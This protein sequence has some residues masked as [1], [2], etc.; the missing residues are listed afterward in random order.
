MGLCILVKQQQMHPKAMHSSKHLLLFESTLYAEALWTELTNR[1]QFTHTESVH[2]CTDVISSQ[3]CFH[4]PSAIKRDSSH[5]RVFAASPISLQRRWTR[6]HG[7]IPTS[8]LS[9]QS[10]VCLLSLRP[11]GRR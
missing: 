1:Q 5:R 3:H 2:G 6:L 8:S 10:S 7:S 9:F 11:G 4:F